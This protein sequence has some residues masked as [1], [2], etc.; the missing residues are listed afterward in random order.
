MV[1]SPA[2]INGGPH[3][4]KKRLAP[5]FSKWW[6]A[7]NPN[8]VAVLDESSLGANLAVSDNIIYT[9]VGLWIKQKKKSKMQPLA[10]F[11]HA[12]L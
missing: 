1:L 9:L 12:T 3:Q 11:G 8:K 7:P 10:A 5:P 2:S 4:F 6:M